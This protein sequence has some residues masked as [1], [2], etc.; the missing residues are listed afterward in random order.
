[1]QFR[2]DLIWPVVA[3]EGLVT[4]FGCLKD[5]A[6]SVHNKREAGCYKLTKAQRLRKDLG[7]ADSSLD[8]DWSRHALLNTPSPELDDSEKEVSEMEKVNIQR[9]KYMY[10]IVSNTFVVLVDEGLKLGPF[11]SSRL[12]RI[13]LLENVGFWLLSTEYNLL[14]RCTSA[15]ISQLSTVGTGKTAA[16]LP[17]LVWT[18]Q[19]SRRASLTLSL[20]FFLSELFEKHLE[21]G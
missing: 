10:N 17:P 20:D 21:K 5:V 19:L 1:M 7:L 3:M 16:D 9:T 13:C 15:T 11:S 8:M 2:V 18:R 4:L 12:A 14:E 6:S